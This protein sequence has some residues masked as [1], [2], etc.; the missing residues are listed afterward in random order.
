M[1][2]V[3]HQ[4]QNQTIDSISA[5]DLHSFLDVKKDFS[6][7]IKGFIETF[8][9]QEG[10]DY[11]LCSPLK[12]EQSE[13]VVDNKEL[14]GGHNKKEYALSMEA[15]KLICL[16]SKKPKG[17]E[18]RSKVIRDQNAT[19]RKLEQLEQ[20]VTEVKKLESIG[21]KTKCMSYWRKEYDIS[22]PVREMN[23]A[24]NGKGWLEPEYTQRWGVTPEGYD[25]GIEREGKN[26]PT[27]SEEVFLNLAN[28]EGWL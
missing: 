3:Q 1:N 9:L 26:A 17:V 2:I 10:L 14:R 18:Y 15:V 19:A 23:K 12:G 20:Q 5:R 24:A 4:F 8:D 21:F 28:E 16:L 11:E 22:L 6:N 25:T 27:F 13:Q 7:W